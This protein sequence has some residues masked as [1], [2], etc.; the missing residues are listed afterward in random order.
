MEQAPEPV[1]IDKLLPS[2]ID[3]ANSSLQATQVEVM[4][5]FKDSSAMPADRQSNARK[6]VNE[7]V[8]KLGKQI[9]AGLNYDEC[10]QL[11]QEIL[12]NSQSKPDSMDYF[13][14]VS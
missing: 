3:F 2:I 4:W 7:E 8:V 11:V 14:S 9:A 5:A 13:H 6:L 12:A 1:T 10:V